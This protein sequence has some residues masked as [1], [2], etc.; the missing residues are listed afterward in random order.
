M[1]L[2]RP[3]LDKSLIDVITLWVAAGA[4]AAGWVPGTD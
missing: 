1:P 3:K 2:D 4:P